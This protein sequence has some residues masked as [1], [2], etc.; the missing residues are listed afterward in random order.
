[1]SRD[2]QRRAMREL[3][4]GLI[5]QLEELYLQAFDDIS[6]QDLGEGAIARLT[7]LLLRSREA[8]ITPLHEEIEAPLITRAP[9]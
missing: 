7:Q 5:N 6:R 2:D 3:R 4:E 9:Q 1:M 8:A